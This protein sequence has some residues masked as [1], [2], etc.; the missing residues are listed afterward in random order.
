MW[1]FFAAATFLVSVASF[2][3]DFIPALHSQPGRYALFSACGFLLVLISWLVVGERLPAGLFRPLRAALAPIWPL[4]LVVTLGVSSVALFGVQALTNAHQIEGGFLASVSPD[5]R[6]FQ[7]QLGLVESRVDSLEQRTVAVEQ[8][9]RDLQE[10]KL[11]DPIQA[12]R[13]M[14]YD[15]AGNYVRNIAASG[16]LRAVERLAESNLLKAN[17]DALIILARNWPDLPSFVQAVQ[18]IASAQ[19]RACRKRDGI[20]MEGFSD[21]FTGMSLMKES[22]SRERGLRGL[23]AMQLAGWQGGESGI[24]ENLKNLD[25]EKQTLSNFAIVN[26]SNCHEQPIGDGVFWPPHH[27]YKMLVESELGCRSEQAPDA[28][29]DQPVYCRAMKCPPQPPVLGC[30]IGAT[31]VQRLSYAS[32]LTKLEPDIAKVRQNL[33][34]LRQ[35]CTLLEAIKHP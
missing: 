21:Q 18:M 15:L 2:C 32:C 34:A 24:G 10:C 28:Y 33:L 17:C 1:R 20:L 14:G 3:F 4:P 5:V 11:S 31:P 13:C 12:L 26:R 19:D 9:T 27:S 25:V 16:N 7:R 35:A 22:D 29:I 23:C 6:G 30:L 8:S